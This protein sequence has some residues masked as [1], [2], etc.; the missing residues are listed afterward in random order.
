VERVPGAQQVERLLVQ[1]LGGWHGDRQAR[2]LLLAKP[3]EEQ[4]HVA[5]C[6]E[7]GED[8]AAV[9]ARLEPRRVLAQVE[10]TLLLGEERQA[11][12]A[13]RGH[14]CGMADGGVEG[15]AGAGV[16]AV[17]RRP[18]DAERVQR[19][20]QR[21]GEVGDLGALLRQRVGRAVA[22]V[23]EGDAGEAVARQLLGEPRVR[24]PGEGR[25]VEDDDGGA[26]AGAAVVHLPRALRAGDGDEVALDHGRIIL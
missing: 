26:G 10:V 17:Q 18:F 11:V 1:L 6:G 2:R 21:V 19:L 25:L 9:P 12:Q 16:R 15:D 20:D 4:L 3:G 22:G 14:A 24:P 5:P 7:R 13:D 8:V 23:V